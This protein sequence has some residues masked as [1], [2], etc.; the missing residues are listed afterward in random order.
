MAISRLGIYRDIRRPEVS[1]K[2]DKQLR[3]TIRGEIRDSRIATLEEFC[4][5]TNEQ[6]LSR[7]IKLAFLIIAGKI[8]PEKMDNI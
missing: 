4:N 6:K 8:N 1:G 5:F 3:R 2:K 7:R